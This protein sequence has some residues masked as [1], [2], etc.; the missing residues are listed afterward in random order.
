MDTSVL[1][2]SK[3]TGFTDQRL[4]RLFADNRE[5]DLAH[6]TFRPANRGLRDPK[7]DAGFA[8]HLMCLL[9]EFLDHPPLSFD[10]DAMRHLDQQVNQAVHDL[11]LTRDAVK[12]K[13]CQT[14]A[15]RMAA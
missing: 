2:G 12:R 7:Q 1:R 11:A 5:D 6:H 8:A 4:E 10:G 3:C 13:Q 15:L 14:Y 9:D